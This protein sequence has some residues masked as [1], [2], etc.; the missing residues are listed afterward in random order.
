MLIR[1]PIL[2][3]IIPL[4]KAEHGAERLRGVGVGGGVVPFF[5]QRTIDSPQGPD[6]PREWLSDDF[7][8]CWLVRQAGGTVRGRISPTLGREMPEI[9]YLRP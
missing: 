3:R 7:A 1:K 2:R 5:R 9:K 4:L 8:F 6:Q